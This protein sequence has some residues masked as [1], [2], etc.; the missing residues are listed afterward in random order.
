MERLTW[1]NWVGPKCNHRCPYKRKAEGDLTTKEE[2][3]I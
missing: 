2:R 1:I 3:V